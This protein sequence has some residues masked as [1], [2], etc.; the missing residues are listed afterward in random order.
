MINENLIIKAQEEAEKSFDEY[1]Y[2]YIIEIVKS[3]IDDK[4]T[5]TRMNRTETDESLAR[6]T[7]ECIMDYMMDYVCKENVNPKFVKKPIEYKVLVNIV[8]RIIGILVGDTDG[9]LT[10]V[11]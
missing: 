11:Y 2:P 8:N 10:P 1:V 3:I 7:G 9:K 6:Y 4:N 5:D